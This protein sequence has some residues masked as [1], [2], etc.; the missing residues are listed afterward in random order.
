MGDDASVHEGLGVAE[1]RQRLTDE[2]MQAV[3]SGAS[4]DLM[5]T[6][7]TVLMFDVRR[8][9][10]QVEADTDLSTGQSVR[11]PTSANEAVLMVRL[12]MQYLREHAPERLAAETPNVR[13]EAVP[14][15][16]QE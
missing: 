13:A 15:A 1:Y 4:Y 16:A 14:T 3:E 5:R 7:A 8:L 11:R 6:A 2:A 9:R 12:G 10:R